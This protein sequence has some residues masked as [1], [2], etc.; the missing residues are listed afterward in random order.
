MSVFTNLGPTLAVTAISVA[1]CIAGMPAASTPVVTAATVAVADTGHSAAQPGR[2]VDDDPASFTPHIMEGDVEAMVRVGNLVLVG[3]TFTRV[4]N[5]GTSTDIPR[6][7]LF[8]FDA[9]TGQV[10]TTFA[11]D[12]DGTV[13]TIEAATDGTSAYVGGAFGSVRSG[14][15]TVAVSKL[16]RVDTATGTRITQFQAGTLNGTVRD[17]SVVGNHLWIAGKFTHVQGQARRALATINA[18]TGGRDGFYD[19]VL[20][21]AHRAGSVTN[22]QEITTSPDNDQL[23]AV[24]NFDTLDGLPRHQLAVLDISGTNAT[25]AD[26]RA[27]LFES[28]CNPVF[29]TYM[30]DAQFSPDGSFF[31]VST[32]GAYGGLAA[33]MNGTSG[34]DVV[35]RFESGATGTVSP[36][37]TAYTGGDTTWTI[38]V[39]Q[40][41]VYAGGHQRWQNNPGRGDA[42]GQ[43][44]VS[45]PGIAAL[46][47]VNGMPYSWNPT[48]TL[49]AG[50]RDMI[51]TPEGLFVGSDTDVFAGE[52]HRR[53][54]FLPLATGDVLPPRQAPHLPAEIFRVNSGQSQLLRRSFD[55]TQV[56]ASSDAPNGTGWGSAVGA[57]MINGDLYTAYSNGT[58]TRR[59]FDGTTYGSAVTV[60]AADQL[61]AQ[62]DW[63]NTDLPRVTSMFYDAGWLYFTTSLSSQLFRRAF[64]PESGV[65][66][67]QR[68]SVPSVTGVNYLSMRG[69]FLVDSGFY[70]G[71]LDGVL[72]RADWGTHGA[73]ASTATA[74]TGAGG[75]WSS[76]VLFPYQ[77]PPIAPPDPD[78]AVATF[79]GAATTAGNR[80]THAVQIPSSVQPGDQLLL[81]F[82]ANTTAP[83]YTGPAGW[84][85]VQ[86]AVAGSKATGR[87]YRRTATA[88]D[89]GSSVAV[90]SSAFAKSVLTVAAYR[91]DDGSIDAVS[92]VATETTTATQ[93]VTPSLSASGTTSWL[94]SFWS[95][96]SNATTAWSLPP[97]A[98]ERSGASGTGSGRVSGVLAD[99]NGPVL[100][101][102]QGGLTATAD[103]DGSA[104]IT[105]SVLLTP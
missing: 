71:S 78:P 61:A 59:S 60:N 73:V 23:V 2:I 52:T 92:A 88:A 69:A 83:T 7:N 12:P 3:G 33:S 72:R 34:C 85:E 28:A 15:S 56:T 1:L 49:G 36:T 101:G 32:T 89:P 14:G 39:T 54:A 96:K 8:A 22:V 82:V 42:A 77:G 13:F 35:A 20:A 103:S 100:P 41:V 76:R 70:F 46:D 66:G 40:D 51:A 31:V 55:G 58:F 84:D 63:H 29:E 10:S 26:Y 38:E 80:T 16:Y 4:R 64:S 90:T 6:R 75:G 25:V 43:G 91:S 102:P 86:A 27:P 18:T 47:T 74:V 48:R 93:H 45:R 17:L 98:T 79:V 37:W 65:V 21:G 50:V 5:A 30:T 95:D 67:Q 62:T 81:H 94:I 24:G 104:A 9:T 11:P 57:F 87:L 19:R 97:G 44:A 105:F 99:S 53:V 68:F